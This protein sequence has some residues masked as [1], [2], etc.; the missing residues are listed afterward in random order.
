VAQQT[1]SPFGLK[2][3]RAQPACRDIGPLAAALIPG[4]CMQIVSLPFGVHPAV[5]RDKSNI[6][7]NNQEY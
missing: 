6:Y 4:A 1:A 7:K 3:R 2:D 5:I